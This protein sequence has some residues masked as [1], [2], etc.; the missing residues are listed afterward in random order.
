MSF[1]RSAEPSFEHL[2]SRVLFDSTIVD[3]GDGAEKAVQFVD[4]DG[5]AIVAGSM[6][7]RAP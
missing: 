7:G 3:F 1:H 6:G 5:S 4:A 2:E